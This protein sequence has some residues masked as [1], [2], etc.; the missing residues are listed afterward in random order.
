MTIETPV[1]SAGA[2]GAPPAR[3]RRRSVG[4]DGYRHGDNP[5]PAASRVGPLVASGGILGR[6]LPDGAFGQT[7]QDQSALMFALLRRVAE[8][9]GVALEDIVKVSIYLR[10]G[11]PKDALNDEWVR[12]FPDPNSRPARHVLV[13]EHLPAQALVQCDFLALAPAPAT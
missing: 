10:P 12:M 4:V 13:Y 5:I 3:V 6:A 2:A 9:A 8:A 1:S 7:L 11:L